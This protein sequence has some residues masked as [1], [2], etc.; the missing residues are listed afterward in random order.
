[1]QLCLQLP[2]RG[3]NIE[4]PLQ[5]LKNCANHLGPKEIE[6]P[7]SYLVFFFVPIPPYC[8]L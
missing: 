4:S 2:W 1:M 8:L 6:L 3:T 5:Q 7:V